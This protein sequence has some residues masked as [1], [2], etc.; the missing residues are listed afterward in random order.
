MTTRLESIICHTNTASSQILELE[1]KIRALEQRLKSRGVDLDQ[2]L[3]AEGTSPAAGGRPSINATDKRS[4]G[5]IPRFIGDESGTGWVCRSTVCQTVID[6]FKL[7]SIHLTCHPT[8]LEKHAVHSTRPR[9]IIWT[10]NSRSSRASI[11]KCKRWSE[12]GC[13]LV[14]LIL[15]S[16]ASR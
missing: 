15:L 16:I 6:C 7:Y 14:S 10:S 4:P 1:Q 2:P 13:C 8:G 5:N 11:A 9:S 12:F 3:P